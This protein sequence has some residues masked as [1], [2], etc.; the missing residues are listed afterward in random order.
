MK[1]YIVKLKGTKKTNTQDIQVKMNCDS[2]GQAINLAYNFFQKGE[3]NTVYGSIETGLSTI[4]RWMPEAEK[5]KKYA[6]K[7]IVYRTSVSLLK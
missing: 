4:H 5:M 7:Y 2:K 6:G 1:T 3:I